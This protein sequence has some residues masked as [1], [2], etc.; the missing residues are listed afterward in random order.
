MSEF[1]KD[2]R[3]DETCVVGDECQ[4]ADGGRERGAAKHGAGLA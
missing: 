2:I 4:G 3:H 1:T